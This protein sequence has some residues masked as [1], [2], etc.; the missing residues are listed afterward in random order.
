M[1]NLSPSMSYL[2]VCVWAVHA[3]VYVS[4]WVSPSAL[5]SA[6]GIN[7][8]RFCLFS[9]ISI[10]WLLTGSFT[11][12]GSQPGGDRWSLRPFVCVFYSRPSF[13]CSS[14]LC[15]VEEQSDCWKT[16]FTLFPALS[17]FLPPVGKEN[18]KCDRFSLSAFRLNGD[19]N[20]HEIILIVFIF[21]VQK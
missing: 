7:A 11:T 17:V 4:R 12:H 8:T 3:C 20:Q 9:L 6:S 15:L 21:L 14:M 2:R 10:W 13:R 5:P 19:W 18:P 16:R 1:I